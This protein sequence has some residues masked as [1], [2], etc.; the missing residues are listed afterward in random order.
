M[1]YYKD[2]PYVTENLDPSYDLFLNELKEVI[3]LTDK[4]FVTQIHPQYG[5]Y[6]EGFREWIEKHPEYQPDPIA[7]TRIVDGT[8]KEIPYNEFFNAAVGKIVVQLEQ[9]KKAVDV[10]ADP[11]LDKKWWKEYISIVQDGFKKDEW[12]AV[13]SMFLQTPTD[14]PISLIIGP[15]DN[16]HDKI[17]GVKRSFSAWFLVRNIAAQEQTNLLINHIQAIK[18]NVTYPPS[19][20]VSF[21]IGDL[22]F[23]GGEV[24]KHNTMGWSRAGKDGKAIKLIACNK[25]PDH[26]MRMANAMHKSLTSWK[27]SQE[28]GEAVMAFHMSESLL[29]L[30]LHEYSHTYN[31]SPQAMKQL[32]VYYTE[33]EESRANAYMVHLGKILENKKQLPPHTAR[34]MFLRVLLYLPY[35]YE[36]F[37]VRQQREAYYF[38]GLLWLQK[39]KEYGIVHIAETITIDETD[40]DEK[41]EN[42]INEIIKELSEMQDK[43]IGADRMQ[44]R[45]EILFVLGKEL[46]AK[47]SW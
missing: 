38:A 5:M 12:D 8:A 6:T 37:A 47:L 16:Y 31:K 13:E 35:L 25:L 22:L 15:I 42:I 17:K 26:T 40:L 32:G 39:A 27:I 34:N 44:K 14:S 45:K 2:Y 28:L 10:I 4:L 9:V 23:A 41:I 36:E 11:L 30:T 24:A 1:A 29:P 20:D 19:E 7:I 21:F 18:E 33:S 46:A 3:V 43:G